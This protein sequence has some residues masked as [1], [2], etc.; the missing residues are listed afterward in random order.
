MNE[1][2][3]EVEN[4]VAGLRYCS[5]LTGRKIGPKNCAIL[6][7]CAK[8]WETYPKSLVITKKYRL[9]PNLYPR[10]I[11]EYLT[12]GKIKIQGS[13]PFLVNN[14]SRFSYPKP[15]F[16]QLLGF[17]RLICCG[18]NNPGLSYSGVVTRMVK[19]GLTF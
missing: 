7:N 10:L 19:K 2:F 18:K 4:M 14:F 8:C 6:K 3:L 9:R 1:K 11:K 16:A 17:T 5:F 13:K 12:P 15:G